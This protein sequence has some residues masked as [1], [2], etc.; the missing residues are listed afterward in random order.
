MDSGLVKMYLKQAVEHF[1][2]A[3][4]RQLLFNSTTPKKKG[5]PMTF[6][7][8]SPIA[9]EPQSNSRYTWQ[10]VNFELFVYDCEEQIYIPEQVYWSLIM[11]N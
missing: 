7:S 6:I 2:T 5:A 11:E 8:S 4:C 10:E 9:A 3:C 1:S